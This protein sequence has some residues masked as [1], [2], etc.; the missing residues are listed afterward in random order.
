MS[1]GINFDETLIWT[2]WIGLTTDAGSPPA[3]TI[4]PIFEIIP[5]DVTTLAPGVPTLMLVSSEG[6]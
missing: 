2:G 1:L 3:P 6:I 4:A 5:P